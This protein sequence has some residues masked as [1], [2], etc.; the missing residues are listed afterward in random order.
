MAL[1][2]EAFPLAPFELG[3]TL[4][5]PVVFCLCMRTGDASYRT[6]LRPLSEG[7]R[8]PRRERAKAATELLERYVDLLEHWATAYPWQ[9]FNF[10]DFWA[11]EA[12]DGS[13]DA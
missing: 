5:C 11:A 13:S 7:V 9:W 2:L 10:Y 1:G 6:V 12:E 4:G 3:V 8:A